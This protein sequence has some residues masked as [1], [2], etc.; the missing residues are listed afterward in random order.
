MKITFPNQDVISQKQ[1]IDLPQ[2][3]YLMIDKHHI[4]EHS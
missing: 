3:E 4:I 2:N 1:I